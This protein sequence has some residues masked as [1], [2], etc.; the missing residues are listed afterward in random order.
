M[1]FF[2]K[3]TCLGGMLKL[4]YLSTASEIQREEVSA[5]IA[6]NFEFRPVTSIGVERLFSGFEFIL[7]DKQ[8]YCIKPGKIYC[9]LLS[10]LL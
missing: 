4:M 8:A 7:Y 1:Q 9:C 10:Q 2:I 3:N 5:E 6:P